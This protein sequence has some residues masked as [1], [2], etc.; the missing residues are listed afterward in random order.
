MPSEMFVTVKLLQNI[1]HIF[2]I[3][4]K[5]WLSYTEPTKTQEVKAQIDVNQLQ[6]TQSV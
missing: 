5:R 4:Y 6:I 1:F 3:K 2:F